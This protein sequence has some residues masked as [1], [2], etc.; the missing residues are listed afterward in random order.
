[1]KKYCPRCEEHYDNGQR[2]YCQYDG[3]LL[4][5]PDPYKLVGKTLEDRYQLDALVGIGGFGAVYQAKHPG[6]R[7]AVAFKILRPDVALTR[8]KAV[9][10]FES[11]AQTAAQFNHE[12][13][14][15]IFDAGRIQNLS[16]IAME[17]LEGR[18]LE[19]ELETHGRLSPTRTAGILRPVAAALA[20]AHAQGA[21]IVHRDLKPANVMLV[22]Q[23]PQAE[24][25]KVVDFGIAKVLGSLGGALMS[26][27]IGTPIY[28]APEQGQPGAPIDARADIYALG[29]MLYQMLTG[30][31][32]FSVPRVNDAATLWREL[33][34]LKQIASL[35]LRQALPGAPADLEKLL[36]QM[37]AADP[38]RISEVP[39]L[40]EA[41]CRTVLQETFISE[42]EYVPH[43]EWSARGSQFA[44]PLIPPPPVN[45]PMSKEDT[46]KPVPTQPVSKED[47]PKP[48]PPPLELRTA[49][50]VGVVKKKTVGVL[51]ATTIAATALLGIGL[52]SVWPEQPAGKVRTPPSGASAALGG[53]TLDLSNSVKLQMVNLPGGKFMM[54][55]NASGDEKPLREVTISPFA[56]GK[57]EVT[58]VQWRA[59]MNNNPSYQ[60]WSGELPVERVSWEDTQEFLSHLREKTGEVGWRLPTEAEWE[61]AARAGSIGKFS[62]GD[63][64]TELHNYAWF[65]DNSDYQMHWRQ[66]HPVGQ[67]QANTFGLFDMHGNVSEW[68][69]DWYDEDYY[70]HSPATNPP[71]PSEGS[72]R[73]ERYEYQPHSKADQ[74]RGFGTRQ[75]P[76]AN[77][78]RGFGTRQRG[79]YRVFR[80]G[81]WNDRVDYCRAAQRSY[82]NLGDRSDFLGFRLVRT[83]R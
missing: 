49:P 70:Q 18:P 76:K 20:H 62:F 15:T 33:T 2:R 1:M 34:Q 39:A 12:N 60:T 48:V 66:T 14:V 64:E 37:L 47:A 50:V 6:T 24:Q 10:L 30:R 27:I 52:W 63:A 83:P 43:E 35:P 55:S 73:T 74:K 36:L 17:W 21:G 42:T 4:S 45:Q 68:V 72:Y 65:Y 51:V 67:L 59:L 13:I 58:Q 53:F 29:V 79:P 80:G 5:L 40:F 44:P 31:W 16:F 57:Y 9:G 26:Q 61:Y 78:K 22:Q 75:N 71:G 69:Q 54:G 28:A 3:V 8:P 82:N 41:A 11:E 23:Y 25:V 19:E 7:R 32:P 56:M 77:Q 38:Q 46:P 81:S